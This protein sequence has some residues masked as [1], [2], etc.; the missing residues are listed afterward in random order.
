MSPTELW[1]NVAAICCLVLISGVVAG[2]SLGLMSL[3][4]TNLAILQIAGT[5]QQ[6]LYATR[7]L[8]IR[9]NGHIL[10]STLLLTNTV[11]NETLPILFDR[12]FSTGF[13]S[14]LASTVLLVLFS[15]IIPQAIFSK[16]GL[17]IGATF[18]YPVRALIAVWFV[19]TWPI[20]KF[21]DTLLGSHSGVSYS[22]AE[23]GALIGLHDK[24]KY[25]HGSLTAQTVNII[26]NVLDMQAGSADQFITSATKMLIVHSDMV[27]KTTMIEEYTKQGYSHI[28][29]HK[30]LDEKDLVHKNQIV[31]ALNMDCLNTL[32]EED[33]VNPIGRM[34]LSP[35]LTVSSRI[36]GSELL[37]KVLSTSITQPPIL[38]YRTEEDVGLFKEEQEAELFEMANI[39]EKTLRKH[40]RGIICLIRRLFKCKCYICQKINASN[41]P[42]EITD[43]A[44]LDFSSSSLATAIQSSLKPG[45]LGM[46]SYSQVINHLILG[47]SKTPLQEHI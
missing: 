23:M 5:P 40:K 28:F 1:C 37:S 32:K 12:I 14:I 13:I 46:I 31:G 25:S 47:P 30:D 17:A 15:E 18:A 10:L 39:K 36:T 34:N 38:V 22:V 20:A 35:C 41:H 45:L 4:A 8:P 33:L 3:D 24:S 21:L 43:E 11:L 16:H 26:Q 42:I 2:L 44:K 19:V 7:I 9:K 6:K 29:V 27:L